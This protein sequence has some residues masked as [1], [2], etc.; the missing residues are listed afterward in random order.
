MR[1]R[2]EITTGLRDWGNDG[3]SD[4][5]ETVCREISN[6]TNLSPIGRF[7]IATYYHHHLV[8]RLRLVDL[9]RREPSIRDVP[10]EKPLFIVGLYRTG[11]TALHGLLAEDPRHR[12]PLTWELLSPTPLHRSAR[13]DR[14]HRR[15]RVA[16]LL[17]FNR[18]MMPDQKIAHNVELD[19]PEECFFSLENHFTSSTLFNSFQGYRYAFDLL[20]RDLRS[21]YRHERYHLQVLSWRQ[22][23]RDWILKSPFH[24]WHLDDLMDVFPD[25]RIVFTH[26]DVTSALP[27]NCS[28]SAMTSTKLARH[29]DLQ[30]LGD[31]WH[32]YY[33]A[34]VDRFLEHRERIPAEQVFDVSPALFD[35]NPVGAVEAIYDHFQWDLTPEF[36][37]RMTSHL[38]REARAPRLAHRY[39]LDMFGFERESIEREFADYSTYTEAL[40]ASTA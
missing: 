32:R 36:R 23:P 6:Q 27:S 37:S 33:R 8:N 19:G 5:L 25:A 21:S 28:L 31:F 9:D 7:G 12:A 11:T 2:A 30:E 1:R 22:E 38:D 3:F 15:L 16:S 34:G 35:R 20:D 29:V 14:Q 4:N 40:D 17:W 39:S 13:L 26:R 24:L 18:V 10:I